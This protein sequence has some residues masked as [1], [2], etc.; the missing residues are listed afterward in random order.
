MIAMPSDTLDIAL[1]LLKA[2]PTWF[3]FPIRRLEKSP[4]LLK[5]ELELASNDPKQIRAWH[6]RALGANWGIALKKSHLIVVDV[7]T[8]PGK[9]GRET[10]DDLEMTHG[11][12][13]DTFCVRTPSGGKHYYFNEAHG[14]VHQH[15]LG[16]YG[17]GPD[18]DSTNYVVAPGCWLSN[19]G[20]YEIVTQ[21]IVAPTP[22]WFSAYLQERTESHAESDQTPEIDLDKPAN[23]AWA[24]HYLEN[25]APPSVEGSNGEFALLLAA[26]ELKDHG[27]AETTA[28]DLLNKYYNVFGKCEPLWAVGSG[29]MADRLDVKVHNAWLYLKKNQPG[30]HTAE[31]EFTTAIAAL[32]QEQLNHLAAR[33]EADWAAYH[34]IHRDPLDNDD[35][36]KPGEV[37][38]RKAHVRAPMPMLNPIELAKPVKTL[39][40]VCNRWVWC[41]GIKRFIN[42]LD[43]TIQWDTTQF[44]S[45]YNPYAKKSA[46]LSKALFKGD[47]IERFGWLAFRPGKDEHQGREYNVWRAGRIKPEEGD[48]TIWDEHL[49]Y[50]FQNEQDRDHV[51]NWMAWILKNPTLKPNHA[52][53]IVGKNTGTG[54]SFLARALERIVDERNTQ[55][56]KNSSMGGDFNSWL[57]DC[58]LCVIEEVMQVGRREN[59]NALRDLIT[60]PTVEV[61]MKGIP[62]FK[63]PNYVCMM[64]I[65]NHPDAL[66]LD[67]HD[68][69][70][71]IVETHATRSDPTY[72]ER[73]FSILEDDSALAAIYHALVHRDL[74]EYNG[75]SAAPE[76]GAREQM[77][78]LSRTDAE[79]WLIENAGNVPLSYNIVTVEDVADAMPPA[80][81]RTTRLRTA[82]IP[83]FLKDHLSGVRVGRVRMSDNSR[84]FMWVLHGRYPMLQNENLGSLYEAQQKGAAKANAEDAPYDFGEEA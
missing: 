24:I 44:D 39:A 40:D 9:R 15:R 29:P 54:K 75:L 76:T 37:L 50:L 23:I 12:L 3:L 67:E 41:T 55:R 51:L 59:L 5:N 36:E 30:A 6:A 58:R 56:P 21:G 11:A 33:A 1:D 72:Y 84:R 80:V 31:A 62:A 28:I 18:V 74:G 45:E 68:R 52:L 38:A 66:P 78:E 81:Q 14:V 73:L 7:D 16:K 2:H 49:N 13:P 17:F 82:I 8:K 4:P 20:S 42:R 10:L 61:N 53:L 64:G 65:S 27:I 70:W 63:I 60:E 77:I 83:A 32:D 46:S 19:G 35:E 34:K 43:P 57:K 48:T 26:G 25:D 22:A 47:R 71:L 79:S 69:R